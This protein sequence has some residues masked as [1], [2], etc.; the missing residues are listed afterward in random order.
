M[1]NVR[2]IVGWYAVRKTRFI[3]IV[4]YFFQKQKVTAYGW[5]A[6][7]KIKFLTLFQQKKNKNLRRIVGWYAVGTLA[8]KLV[9]LA[10]KERRVQPLVVNQLGLAAGVVTQLGGTNIP[11]KQYAK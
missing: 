5:Y 2:P 10:L 11:A 4:D 7:G 8:Q 1:K 9:Q 6:V 3:T